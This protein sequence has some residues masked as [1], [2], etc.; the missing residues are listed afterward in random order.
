MR[1]LHEIAP[2]LMV[3]LAA[4]TPAGAA[5]LA[6]NFQARI[7]LQTS[8]LV[9]ATSLNFGNVGIIIG[10]ETATAAVNVICSLGTPYTIS[11]NASLPVTGYSGQMTSGVNQVNYSA[12]LSGSGG[13]GPGSH[14]IDGVLLA[15]AAPP[16]G[17]YTDNRTVYLNY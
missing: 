15:Q 10:G 12:T 13:I 5:Q 4:A 9:T 6:A 16:S 14:T 3:I 17:I 7:N 2:P 8:C 11:F 1:K